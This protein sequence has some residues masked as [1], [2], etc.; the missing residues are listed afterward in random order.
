MNI[1]PTITL[2]SLGWCLSF[3]IAA[4]EAQ[5]ARS[6]PPATTRAQAM[7]K[8]A[9]PEPAPAGNLETEALT[10]YKYI[11]NNFSMKFHKPACPFAKAMWSGH[12]ELFHFR[13]DAIA[14]KYAPCRYCLPPQWTSVSATILGTPSKTATQSGFQQQSSRAAGFPSLRRAAHNMQ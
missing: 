8:A 4:A 3:T 12:T 2:L 9:P 1:S 10:P 11:G 14:A 6:K 5:P 13:K 7:A